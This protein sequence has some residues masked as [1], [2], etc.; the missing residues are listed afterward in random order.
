MAFTSLIIA[1]IS[2]AILYQSALDQHR[3]RLTNAVKS[4]ARLIESI[5]SF[6]AFKDGNNT[7]DNWRNLTLHQVQL[8]HREFEGFGTTGEYAL[9]SLSG[10]KIEFVLTHR[11]DDIEIERTIPYQGDWAEPMRMA[12]HGQSGTTIGR[13]YRGQMVLAAFEPVAILD[14]GLTAKIDL[15]EIRA[16]FIQTGLI[17]FGIGFVIIVIASRFFFRIA[18]PI[19]Q[20]IEQQAETFRTLAETAHEG[21]IVID[22]KGIIQY[23]NPSAE[24][25]FG[26]THNSLPG[27]SVNRLMSRPMR[28]QHN[29]FIDNYLRTGVKKIIGSGR[30]LIGQRKDGSQFP[31][32]LS[33]GDINLKHTRLF[34][35]VIMDLSEQQ[36]LQR[37]IMEVPV[38]EQRRIGQELHDGIGQQ[39]TG[40]GM[41][42]TSLLNKASK[43]EHQLATQLTSGLQE[44]LAQVRALS[45]GLVPIEIDAAGFNQALKNLTNDIRRQSHLPVTLNI[46]DEIEFTDNDLVMHLYRIAQEA[47]NNAVKHSNASEI[48]VNIG[49]DGENCLM[50]IS[51]NGKGIPDD[52]DNFEGLGLS[53]MKYRCSLFEGNLEVVTIETGGTRVC[54]RFPLKLAMRF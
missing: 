11:H 46:E 24:A 52:R 48:R 49:V 44:T 25:M 40:L 22:T 21:I 8:A 28:R 26:Y 50:E 29:Q 51:D 37:E 12:L 1:A 2:I 53:I 43:P 6:N 54:C 32:Y 33:I 34:A 23:L 7:A 9:A 42:A 13:D 4:Q 20:Q 39:L 38:R 36:K 17:A 19:T 5:A 15:A 3:L 14:L 35:G 16:P 27:Q 47:L 31:L 10:D 30:Q 18:R 45:R 41:L